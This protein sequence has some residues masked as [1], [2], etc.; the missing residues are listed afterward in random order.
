[1]IDVKLRSISGVGNKA[2]VESKLSFKDRDDLKDFL[3]SMAY[4]EKACLIEI[5]KEYRK[6]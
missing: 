4:N 2:M 1:M 6:K 3:M 5:D